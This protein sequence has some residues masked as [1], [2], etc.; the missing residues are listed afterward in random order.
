MKKVYIK[1]EIMFEDF[2]LSTNIAG[3]CEGEFVNNATKGACAV[4][5][6]GG[7]MIFSEN[8]GVCEFTPGAFGQADD[9]WNGLCYHVPNAEHNLFNS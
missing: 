8:M 3:D 6:T 1:P 9:T 7:V 5:G 4:I 2:T